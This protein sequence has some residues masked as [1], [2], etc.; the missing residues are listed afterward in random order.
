M[1]SKPRLVEYRWPARG[2]GVTLPRSARRCNTSLFYTA[3]PAALRRAFA[4]ETEYLKPGTQALDDMDYGLALGRRFRALKLWFVL[5]Y[6]GRQGLAANPAEN[7]AMAEWLGRAH[8]R[9]SAA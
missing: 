8:P 6:F 3:H 7:L 2:H 5:R 1:G 4:L 9:T